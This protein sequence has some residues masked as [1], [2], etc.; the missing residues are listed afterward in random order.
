MRYGFVLERE[1]KHLVGSGLQLEAGGQVGAE[2]TAL[3]RLHLA[4]DIGFRIQQVAPP[5]RLRSRCVLVWRH[6]VGL[7]IGHQLRLK[8]RL[9]MSVSRVL[10]PRRP[11]PH[12]QAFLAQSLF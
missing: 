3:Q 6:H 11:L 5:Q 10:L 1:V 2:Y 8:I 4:A 7:D 12:P 9:Q